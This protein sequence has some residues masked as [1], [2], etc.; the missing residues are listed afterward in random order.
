MATTQV[1]EQ[2]SLGQLFSDATRD[3]GQL[4]RQEVELAKTETREEIR[5]A[6]RAGAMFGV[7]A[8][9]AF[10]AL[11]LASFAVAWGLAEVMPAGVAFLI[12]ALV[13]GGVAFAAFQKARQRIQQ[14][15]PVPRE[16]VDTIKEDVEWV[17][18]RGS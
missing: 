14:V 9:L 11:L 2:R 18:A 5:Q 8:V 10:V 7:A 15:D 1:D 13:F 16:T 12:V 4:I 6:T 3:L 17:K